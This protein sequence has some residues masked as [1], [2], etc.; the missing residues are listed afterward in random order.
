MCGSPQEEGTLIIEGLLNIAWGLR[1]PIRLQMQDDREQVHLP[2]S[3]W[4]PGR[5][6]CSPKEPSPQDSSVTAQEPSTQPVH[7]AESSR[8]S[9]GPL[10]EDEEAPQL[11][12]TK[13]DAS[14]MSQRRPKCRAPGE[15]QRIRRH[16]FSINGHFYN[17]KGTRVCAAENLEVPSFP[18]SSLLSKDALH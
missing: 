9:S 12:R 4:M 5:P 3:S 16:R 15:A 17:H 18:A 13:S 14:C 11:M 7:K 1:R 8:E 10:E 2:S 6:S